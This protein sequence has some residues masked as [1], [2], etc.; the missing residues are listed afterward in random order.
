[1]ATVLVLYP[2]S[3][4]IRRQQLRRYRWAIRLLGFRTVLA[5]DTAGPEDRR[6]F[7]EVLPLPPAHQVGE[8]VEVLR[9]FCSRRRIDGILAQ[10]EPSL[11][12]GALLAEALGLP[13]PGVEPALRSINKY[14]CRQVLASAGVPV[15]AFALV[16]TAAEVERFAWAHGYPVVLKAVASTLSRLVTLVAAPARVEAA[17]GRMREGLPTAPDVRRLVAFARAAGLD[18]GCDPGREFL[19]EAFCP[20]APVETDGVVCG[21][22]PLSYGVTEQ[23]MSA[24]SR[25]CI[26]GYL[27]PAE[28]S[29]AATARI[30]EVSRAAIG[31]VGLADTGFSVELRE[32]EEA[33]RVIEVNGRL[34]WDE[35]FAD[36][37]E[38][39]TGE[40]PIYHAV[41]VAIGKRPRLR[42]KPG[43]AAV[44]YASCHEDARVLR[45]P[46][47]REV[48]AAERAGARVGLAIAEGGRIWRFGQPKALPHL[49]WAVA[50]D[51]GSSRAAYE[52]ARAA[53]ER[54]AFELEPVE[55]S[56]ARRS[57]REGA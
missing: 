36:L 28:R 53:V 46:G 3:P 48:R 12:A 27:L 42:R 33:V 41:Q 2:G 38:A 13:G 18:L 32:A 9:A 16:R 22:E 39:T 34:G 21:G 54:L 31:A 5:D 56:D 50:T 37:F 4:A 43:A 6:A 7:D 15:P 14:L 17:V 35:G 25:F 10:W 44:A 49:A 40:K 20:G 51:R 30:E 24:P 52:R 57:W 19:V 11:P 23:V 47:R 1:V 26:E 29:A 55:E 8:A 45:V